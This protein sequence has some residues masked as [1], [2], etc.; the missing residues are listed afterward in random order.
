MNPKQQ[1]TCVTRRAMQ[2]KNTPS[3]LHIAPFQWLTLISGM[4]SAQP[5]LPVQPEQPVQPDLPVQPD[6]PVPVQPDQPG[7]ASTDLSF[8]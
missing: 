2:P 8:R 7:I 6:Q 5:D 4:S 1:A 3:E